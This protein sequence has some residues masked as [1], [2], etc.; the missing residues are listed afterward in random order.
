MGVG[1]VPEAAVPGAAAPGDHREAAEL[2]A[3]AQQF[4]AVDRS[5]PI[6]PP[7][8][9]CTVTSASPAVSVMSSLLTRTT[10]RGDHAGLGDSG[11]GSAAGGWRARQRRDVSPAFAQGPAQPRSPRPATA[12]PRGPPSAGPR[13][14]PT[15]CGAGTGAYRPRGGAWSTSSALRP[16]IVR[17]ACAASAGA[18]DAGTA[19]SSNRP[20]SPPRRTVRGGRL[21]D[22][23]GLLGGRG[24]LGRRRL[25]GRRLGLGG[26]RLGPGAASVAPASPPEAAAASPS[27][28]R[29]SRR[30]VAEATASAG[31]S[32]TRPSADAVPS[33]VTVEPSS[34]DAQAPR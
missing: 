4:D 8:P 12:P 16:I 34:R 3:L 20:R 19:S 21:R 14:G 2:S 30:V 33:K 24:L 31:S 11:R 7:L 26:G 18:S 10:L 13:L 25:R 1:A 6:R 22:V 32:V 28:K 23:R 27:A 5:P 9:G 15:V 29:F 17:R